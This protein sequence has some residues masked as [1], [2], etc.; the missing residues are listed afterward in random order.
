MMTYEDALRQLAELESPRDP[1]MD[2]DEYSRWL[3][4]LIRSKYTYVVASQARRHLPARP[5]PLHAPAPAAPPAPW[6]M[7]RRAAHDCLV[8]L[9]GVGRSSGCCR[10][11]GD[12][13]AQRW[14]W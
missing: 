14:V 10:H 1:L 9:H 13:C 7:R 11:A 6:G 5:A 12:G 3:D 4:D 8:S 2:E